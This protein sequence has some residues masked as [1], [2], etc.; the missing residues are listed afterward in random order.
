MRFAPPLLLL[1]M[2]VA[3]LSGGP[4]RAADPGLPAS[5]DRSAHLVQRL[6]NLSSKEA[7]FGPAYQPLYHAALPWYELWGTRDRNPVDPGLVSP[8]DY[9]DRLATALE[10][11]HNFFAEHPGALFPLVFRQGRPEGGEFSINY[12]L[13][14]PAGFPQ[15]AHAF[16]LIIGLHGSG[17]LAHK[18]SFKPGSGPG[19]PTFGVTPIDMEG[20]WQID[21]L[22]AY[23]D[24]LLRILPVDQDRVYLEG[25][26]LGAMA[27]WEWA[28]DNPERFAAISPRAGIG[29]PYRASRLTH[30]PVW[31]I[32]GE[33]DDVIPYGF[34]EEMVS[35]LQAQG[36][37][38][39]LSVLRGGEHNMP[40]DLDQQ[41]VVDWYL[42]QT[43]SPLRAPADPRDA[44]GIR[45]S[46]F[47][48]WKVVSIPARQ[49]WQSKPLAKLDE[50]RI[51]DAAKGLFRKVHDRGDAVD[52]PLMFEI[53]RGTGAA[54]PWLALPRTLHA[55]A[56][57][58][59][60]V[61]LPAALFVRFYGKGPI[62]GAFEHLAAI[63]AELA[64]Q[65]HF[66]KGSV[67]I[68]PLSMWWE[69]PEGIYEC[70]VQ[71]N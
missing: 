69:T 25:H 41:Q 51:R 58:P 30:V 59:T 3:L 37:A 46:G 60:A 67:W 33:N 70:R 15:A 49:A 29:E 21:F 34:E 26:S 56:P 40:P 2:A 44:L 53:D 11:G 32:H 14:L 48:A 62:P 7:L 27:T 71:T 43:R 1:P 65:G 28:L 57:D 8:E 64:A 55:A 13:S 9:A 19:G 63:K 45:P 54:T 38:V 50:D 24:E 36:G 42:R 23:L 35:A 22:N 68:T 47:S 5:S 66:P 61:D 16:P 10:T 52:S 4:A 20:P 12:W 18:I 6:R 17:W 31:A 39:R